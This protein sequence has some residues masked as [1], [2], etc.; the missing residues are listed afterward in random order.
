[1][2]TPQRPISL[3][4]PELRPQALSVLYRRVP[5]S[6]REHLVAEAMAEADAGRVD[7]SGLW[8][9][10]RR[11]RIAGVLLTQTLAGR[12]AAVWAPEVEPIWGRG[13]LAAGLI[14]VALDD[15]RERGVAIAQALVDRDAP[16]AAAADLTRG[17]LPRTTVLT[18]MHRRTATPLEHP[19]SPGFVWRPLCDDTEAEFRSVLERTYAGSLD[20]PELEGV[21]SLDDV[22][23][24]HRAAGRFDPSRWRVGTVPGEP[25]AGAVILLSEVPDRDAW[26]VAYLG[27][28]PAARGRGLG[29]AALAHGLDL[30]RA[31]ASRLELA[32]DDRNHPARKLYDAAGFV[33]FDRR[34]VHLAVLRRDG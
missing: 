6:L 31:S 3:C 25:E 32:V 1:M 24:S 27:L 14:R 22:M 16:R 12:A 10:R 15:M 20:M 29:R 17:G 26:E 4:T 11:G 13:A 7:L 33:P 19:S 9:A 2:T 28:T 34:A 18:Y 8:A 30:A 5:A 21:R 23:A